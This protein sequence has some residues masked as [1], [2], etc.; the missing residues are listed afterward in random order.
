MDD[1]HSILSDDIIKTIA[2]FNVFR[3]PLTDEQIYRFLPRNSVTKEQVS[4]IVKR[5]VGDGILDEYNN[6]YFL[7]SEDRGIVAQRNINEKR[8][9]KMMKYARFVSML[10]KQ[11]PFTRAVF[12]TGSLSK[13]VAAADSDIDFMIVT[14]EERL[15]ICKTFLTF[16]RKIFLLGS[17]KFFCTNF[18]ISEKEYALSERNMYSAIEL[19]TTKVMWNIPSFLEFQR[20]NSWTKDFLPN[21]TPSIDSTVVLSPSRSLFQRLIERVLNLFPLEAMNQ[22]LMNRYRRHWN[23]FYNDLAEEKRA[24]SFLTSPNVS[25]VWKIDYHGI[26][27]NKCNDK[28][29]EIGLKDLYD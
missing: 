18:Y 17:H 21:C 2:Y 20:A 26:I 6:Y 22:F 23:K 5:L 15:W 24:K 1:N 9:H 19:L 7:R 8:A 25:T 10:L 16:F 12:I 27:M 4:D 11:F 13:N 3:Y 29:S 28:L 14:A